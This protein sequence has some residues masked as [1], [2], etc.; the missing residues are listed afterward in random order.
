MAMQSIDFTKIRSAL[1][2]L[3]SDH[4]ADGEHA[5]TTQEIFAPEQH[6]SALDPYT[7]IVVGAR[8]TGKS[9]W[10]G[11][12]NNDDTRA[13]A[14]EFY[15]D[16]GLED[17]I[18]APGYTSLQQQKIL[19]SLVPHGSEIALGYTFWQALIIRSVE[20]KLYPGRAKK[21]LSYYMGKFNDPEEVEVFFDKL[22][23]VLLKKN[24]IILLTFDAL[25]TIAK[26]WSRSNLLLDSL[27][28]V[29]W[30]LRA[31]KFIKAKIFIRP[32]QLNDESLRFVEMPKLRSARVELEWNQVELYGLLFSR[33]AYEAQS[34][35]FIA[36][37][38]SY[39][40]AV[41]SVASSKNKKEW[42]LLYSKDAQQKVMEAFAGLYMG[43]NP[44]KGKTYDWPY[45]HLAD[46]YGNV[47]PR[48]FIKLFVEAAKFG[49]AHST[50]VITAEGIRHGLREASKVRVDQLGVEYIWV[51]RALAPLAGLRVPCEVKELYSRWKE[52]STINIILKASQDESN[53]FLPP[54]PPGTKM[55]KSL[56]LLEAMTKIGLIEYRHDG[57]IDM[58]DLF[59]VAA[60]ML[61]KGG[62]APSKR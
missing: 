30:S 26:Q 23:K 34:E 41:P 36:F 11:V 8:G 47:T 56:A 51:R 61:K 3:P 6:A 9:F 40:Y 44:K 31:Y 29:V 55:D 10:A 60:S 24:K 17:I 37:C 13:T 33:L 14:A 1:H 42:K 20:E 62:L 48:S 22:D 45:K 53:G 46:A 38:K 28:E 12:L 5:P 52:T 58:P 15:P 4:D 39:N 32:E 2:R 43:S 35:D 7:A 50:Q 19:D 18:V 49:P 54:F 57:R 25:D 21:K 27:F 59:R 16:L